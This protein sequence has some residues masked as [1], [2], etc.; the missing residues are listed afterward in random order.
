VSGITVIISRFI[1]FPLAIFGGVFGVAGGFGMG[2]AAFDFLLSHLL[3]I[4][5]GAL[6]GLLFQ[7]A[8]A[9]SRFLGLP[10]YLSATHSS[11]NIKHCFLKPNDPNV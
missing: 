7:I 10:F 1:V 11:S 2:T 3:L 4:Q 5:N 9:L 8:G 6:I